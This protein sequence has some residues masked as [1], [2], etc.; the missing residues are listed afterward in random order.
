M[1]G[2][3]SNYYIILYYSIMKPLYI[4]IFLFGFIVNRLIN[5]YEGFDKEVIYGINSNEWF[6]HKINADY[7]IK[8]YDIL[9]DSIRRDSFLEKS[10]IINDIK[11][12]QTIASL[13][14][15]KDIKE[16]KIN[17]AFDIIDY[18]KNNMIDNVELLHFQNKVKPQHSMWDIYKLENKANRVDFLDNGV[19]TRGEFETWFNSKLEKGEDVYIENIEKSRESNNSEKIN[20]YANNEYNRLIKNYNNNQA[21]NIKLAREML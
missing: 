4:F 5:T 1:N 12:N 10:I 19:I 8:N 7:Y 3:T 6:K 21:L 15:K 17:K 11:D 14:Y 9:Q 13:K 18:N 16:K 20:K 2:N